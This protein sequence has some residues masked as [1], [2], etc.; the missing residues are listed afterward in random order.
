MVHIKTI[1][2]SIQQSFTAFY[3]VPCTATPFSQ[4]FVAGGLCQ[5]TM[6]GSKFPFYLD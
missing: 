6:T 3:R 5:C 4:N 1:Y 2:T